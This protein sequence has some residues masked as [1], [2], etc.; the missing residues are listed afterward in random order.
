MEDSCEYIESSCGQPTRGGPP[1]WGWAGRLK[2]LAVKGQHAAK[3][4]TGPRTWTDSL[5][6]TKQRKMEYVRFSGRTGG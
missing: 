5:E 4:Y 2:L 3:F 6:Q 1:A